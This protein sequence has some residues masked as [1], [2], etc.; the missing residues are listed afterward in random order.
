ME[1]PFWGKI[2]MTMQYMKITNEKDWLEKKKNYVT[3]TEVSSLFGENTYRTAFELYHIKHGNIPDDYQENKFMQFGK[4]IEAPICEMIQIEHPEWK[5]EDFNVFAYDDEYKIGSSFDRK[6]II[7]GK[8]WALEI[9]SISYGQYKEKFI[10]HA[11][12]DIEASPMYEIQMQNELVCLDESFV[13]CVMAVF[14]LDT[15]ELKYIFRDRDVQMGVQMVEA[16][17]EFWAM[18]KAPEPDYARDK[19][20]IAKLCVAL[21]LD[22]NLDCTKNNRI[23]ELAAQYKASMEIIKQEDKASGACYAEIMH[24]LGNAKRA[25]TNHHKITVSDIKPNEGKEIT[26]D[27]VG[28]FTGVRDG[29]R[30]L[31][32]TATKKKE[33][34]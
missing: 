6:V 4:I 14:I 5:I 28:T 7:D 15:R 1:Q 23:T 27:M 11:E 26:Q 8:K 16:V 33:N 12:D 29:Y 25:W 18:K 32:I 2:R 10:E 9:K 20:L 17:Q 21:N 34:K 13:G 24:L 31:T 22:A 30:K 3:S 19:T